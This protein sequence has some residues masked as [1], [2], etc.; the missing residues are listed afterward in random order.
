MINISNFFFRNKLNVKEAINYIAEAWDN[1]TQ[2]TIQNCWKKTGI[3]PSYDDDD[4]DETNEQDL[5]LDEL[6]D[7]DI[8]YLPEADSLQEYFQIL[9]QEIPAEEHLTE[10]QII[11]LVQDEEDENESDTDTD[12]EIP[13]VS[14]KNS[15]DALK[16]FI[17]YLEQ[18]DDAEFSFDDLPIF[19][20]YLRI[21]KTK[22]F[23]TKT[24]RTLDM[25][26]E[27]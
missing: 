1:V 12:E 11:N 19:R 13:P 2:E 14:T 18:Q 6:D 3:L 20:K 27:R 15:L 23:N 7:L 22:E 5:E 17:N 8:D 4:I 26:F 10:D 24:Q 25:Y 21:V 9:D 16:T